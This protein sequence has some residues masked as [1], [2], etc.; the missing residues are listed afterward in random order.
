[1]ISL[2]NDHLYSKLNNY[3]PNLELTDVA[4]PKEFLDT[5]IISTDGIIS[6]KVFTKKT[7][8]ILHGHTILQRGIK[9]TLSQ[10]NFTGSVK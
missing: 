9:G 10:E 3:H 8:K 6:T 4:N 7:N 5:S 1:M 2:L